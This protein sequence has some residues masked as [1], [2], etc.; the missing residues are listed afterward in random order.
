MLNWFQH[1]LKNVK[2]L[3]FPG[4]ND[5]NKNDGKNNSGISRR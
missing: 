1:L 2:T 5:E 4:Y 3:I